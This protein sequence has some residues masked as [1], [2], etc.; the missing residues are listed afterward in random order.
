MVLAHY[1]LSSAIFPYVNH[2]I[3]MVVVV[4]VIMAVMVIFVIDVWMYINLHYFHLFT[5]YS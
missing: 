1:I 5:Y 3:V 4:I 2:P